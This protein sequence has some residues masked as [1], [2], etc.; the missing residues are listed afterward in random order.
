MKLAILSDIHGNLEALRACLEVCEREKADEYVFLGDYT[1]ELPEPQLTLGILYE[2]KCTKRCHFI[3]GNREEYVLAG[4]GKGHP[5]WNEFKSVVGTM[6]YNADR[7]T[8]KDLSFFESLPITMRL[9]YKGLPALRL[10]HG[11]PSKASRALAALNDEELSMIK[12]DIILFGHTHKVHD[13]VRGAK[14]MLNPGSVG[15]PLEGS[16]AQIMFL[17][18][19]NGKWHATFAAVNYDIN[20]EISRLE[21]SG[22][23]NIAPYWTV[24]TISLLQGGSIGHSAVLNRAM[25]ITRRETGRCDW[26][27][28]PEYA[29]ERAARE[30]GF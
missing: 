30:Y 19:I 29:M 11:S 28:I 26:P 20:K 1:G 5:E 22:L 9:E 8:A 25:D 14:R 23:T 7:L 15:I 3:R 6:Q 16:D 12:E 4:L 27:A 13:E 24:V 17:D 18:G 21:E 2:L 10:C